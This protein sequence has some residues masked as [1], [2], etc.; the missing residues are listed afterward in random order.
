[1]YQMN[2]LR[3]GL[4]GFLLLLSVSIVAESYDPAPDFS[5][6]DIYE[7]GIISLK[8]YRGSIVLVD[9]WASWCGPCRVSLPEYNQLRNKMK[10]TLVKGDFEVLA[11]NVD[12]SKEDAMRF[13]DQHPLDFPVLLET[14]GV[15]QQK[16]KLMAM[17]TSFLV[18]QQGLIRI[19][20]QGYSPGYLQVLEK[21]IRQLAKEGVRAVKAA[22]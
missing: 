15:S 9:F 12:M 10:T 6:P 1:M 11:I 14:T 22:K 2:L 4:A 13:L 8:D 21:E 18:D 3:V 17:P 5:L 7:G 20:H 19:A 16:Y